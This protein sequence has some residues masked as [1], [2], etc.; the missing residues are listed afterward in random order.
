[1]PEAARTT[2]EI[3]HTSAL[4][5]LLAGLVAGAVVGLAVGAVVLS[6][7]LAAGPL[8]AAVAT[9][10]SVGAGVGQLLGSL[11]ESVVGVLGGGDPTV[12]IGGQRAAR[13][14]EDHGGCG[15]HSNAPNIAQGSSTVLISCFPA[16]RK[17]DR[18]ECSF[19]ISS[20]CATVLVGGDPQTY[21]DIESEVPLWL[22]LSTIA[23]GIV[24]PAGW[25]RLVGRMTWAGI[26]LN[27]GGGLLGGFGFGWAG[28]KLGGAW[29]GEGS[30]MQKVISFGF[31]WVG[32]GL[33]SRAALRFSQ[34]LGVQTHTQ[35]SSSPESEAAANAIK[36]AIARNFPEGVENPVI[37][38][39]V[40][41]NGAVTYVLSGGDEA[42]VAAIYA[43]LKGKLPANYSAG[44]ASVNK[45]GFFPAT[46]KSGKPRPVPDCAEPKLLQT[47]HRSPI[48]SMSILW[49]GKG[50]NRYADPSRSP[51]LMCPC[52]S[53]IR[54]AS[55]MQRATSTKVP[56]PPAML[57]GGDGADGAVKPSC[58]G[59]LHPALGGGG[60]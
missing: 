49:R 31:A 5:G 11:D 17:G 25:M 57:P 51:N 32:S 36:E 47:K 45:Q 16:A 12:L 40:H 6:G 54:N 53:C 34:K 48:S 46:T 38:T 20:G 15:D 26:G 8:I 21:L 39:T 14:I 9:G 18:G 19:K 55:I 23:L 29:F 24:G 2:D 43:A 13:A 3:S 42:Q 33:T 30:D 7:G 10:A 35:P 50:K 60:W 1:M 27:L 52:S 44:N 58:C 59:E 28:S 37:G 4:R 41:R 56:I 22:E